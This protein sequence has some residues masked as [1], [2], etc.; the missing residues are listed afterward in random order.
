MRRGKI[1]RRQHDAGV[2]FSGIC[3]GSH[4]DAAPSEQAEARKRLEICLAVLNDCHPVALVKASV[5]SACRDGIWPDAA[6][7]M[8][9]YALCDGL[10]ALAELFGV[11]R[12]WKQGQGRRW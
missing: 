1:T 9:H 8:G 4:P 11:P 3:R 5:D 12:G 10:S 7:A 6:T 2:T